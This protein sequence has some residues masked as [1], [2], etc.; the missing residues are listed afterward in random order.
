MS[1]RE[2][3][4]YEPYDSLADALAHVEDELDPCVT[5]ANVAFDALGRMITAPSSRTS[6]P[7]DD[8]EPMYDECE[9]PMYGGLEMPTRMGAGEAIELFTSAPVALGGD[10]PQPEDL[11][12]PPLAFETPPP[13]L[14]PPQGRPEPRLLAG[15]IEDLGEIARGGCGRIHLG[16]DHQL[17]RQVAMKILDV[18]L[19]RS[20]AA[21]QRFF[22]E[23]QI[24]GQLDHPN[25]VPVHELG[26]D[27]EGRRFFAMRMVRGR[28]LSDILKLADFDDF[29]RRDL[30]R[31]VQILIK[32]CDAVGFA[33]NRGVVHRDLKP[34]NI[35]V[36]THGQVYLMD[37]G[38]ARLTA[39]DRDFDDDTVH[40]ARHQ[41]AEV[42]GSVTGTLSYMA[43]EQARGEMACID[44][45]T[46]LYSLGAIL[47]EVLAGVPPHNNSSFH[48]NLDNARKGRVMPVEDA[49]PDRQ[50]PPGL[51]R[52]VTKAL[53]PRAEERFQTAEVLKQDLE[54]FLRGGW[55]FAAQH[56][57]EGSM[58]LTEG[59]EGDAAY[60]VTKGHCEVF[61]A[62]DGKE[63]VLMTLRPGDVFGEIAILTDQPRMASIRALT[64]VSCMVVTRAAFDEE[65]GRNS[66]M[67]AFVKALAD[68]FRD[69]GEDMNAL[70]NEHALAQFESCLLEHMVFHGRVDADG[71]READRLT[72]LDLITG[73][74][75]ISEAIALERIERS[76]RFRY[77]RDRDVVILRRPPG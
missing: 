54:R 6:E 8:G 12:P 11:S 65:L 46:D 49:A 19:A 41:R 13:M 21:V 59:E 52:I 20:N 60:I 4:R 76:L 3:E 22:E 69:Q 27:E 45:R 33:H 68:R 74:L 30:D 50:M 23:A 61:Q 55:W 56:F 10:V 73:A 31:V 42:E 64:P 28:T 75:D 77:D 16:F 70:R 53:A 40:L 5:V 18:D 14:E 24:T 63:N 67:G 1:K 29:S 51:V 38:I 57:T 35:M 58:I 32:V 48:V 44:A 43:P 9:M 2:T 17:L 26:V 72:V 37:W 39:G 62:R 15:R 36:G 34:D 25:I 47:Y 66:W 71:H 7:V